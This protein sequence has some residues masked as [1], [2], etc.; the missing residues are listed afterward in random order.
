VQLRTGELAR[1]HERLDRNYLHSITALSN[2]IE[3]RGG[4][5]AGHSRRVAELSRRLAQV[6]GLPADEVQDVFVAGLL[7]D[8][9]EVGLSDE[10]LAC[11]VA[12]MSPAEK[13][14]YERH[15]ALGEQALLALQDMHRIAALVRAHHERHDGQGFP[16]GLSGA[17]I[18]LGARIL[19]VVDTFDDLQRGHLSRGGLS[20]ADARLMVSRGRGTQFDPAV[21]DA[22]LRETSAAPA[23]AKFTELAVN[24]LR[25]GM[26]LAR[27]LRSH[28]GV[29]LLAA[30]HVL[31]ADLIQ[32]INAYASRHDL[33]L[34]IP[35][36]SC[37]EP[38]PSVL[39]FRILA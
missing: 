19:A 33:T 26:V 22:F 24:D 27:D 18:P 5:T 39:P 34:Q 1:A 14:Q 7:H 2:L 38:F 17:Q 20:L 9:G 15:A 31:D 30:G 35:V 29:V 3:M 25:S 36:R 13:A 11:P 8:I 28:D 37:S 23:E 12:R 10:V 21:V 32:R 4:A 16:E 6:L